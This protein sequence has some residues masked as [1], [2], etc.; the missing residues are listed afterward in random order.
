MRDS[1]VGEVAHVGSDMGIDFTYVKQALP[2]LEVVQFAGKFGAD[3]Y[4][5][6]R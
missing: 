6:L 1:H 2:G 3:T 4:S 5:R